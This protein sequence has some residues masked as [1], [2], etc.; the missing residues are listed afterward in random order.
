M[1]QGHILALALVHVYTF[2]SFIFRFAHCDN[3][4]HG[5][6]VKWLYS[7]EKAENG[8]NYQFYFI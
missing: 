4:S 6:G 1:I 2:Q 8:I 3:L 7:L 5:H